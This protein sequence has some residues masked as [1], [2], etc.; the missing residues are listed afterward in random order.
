MKCGSTHIH[1]DLCILHVLLQ[2]RV[3]ILTMS[4]AKASRATSSSLVAAVL[5]QLA[6]C[7]VKRSRAA[8]EAAV[9]KHG[10][11]MEA[12]VDELLEQEDE[13]DADDVAVVA[14]RSA[15]P[16]PQLRGA[17]NLTDGLT[18]S[19]L[20]RL[21]EAEQLR[22]AM[23]LSVTPKPDIAAAA[24]PAAAVS[25]K[26]AIQADSAVS[27]PCSSAADDIADDDAPPS[28]AADLSRQASGVEAASLDW[29]EWAA[30]PPATHEDE[31][32]GDENMREASR[33]AAAPSAG[34]DGAYAA[35][36][37]DKHLLPAASPS[38]ESGWSQGSTFGDDEDM[39]GE[40]KGATAGTGRH[41]RETVF[42][43][44]AEGRRAFRRDL[45]GVTRVLHQDDVDNLTA[46]FYIDT[47]HLKAEL[48]YAMCLRP[49]TTIE[50]TLD[51]SHGYRG[52]DYPLPKITLEDAGGVAVALSHSLHTWFKVCWRL[53]EEESAGQTRYN[54]LDDMCNFVLSRLSNITAFCPRQTH[55]HTHAR[56]CQEQ[57]DRLSHRICSALM[58]LS[59]LFSMR[60][61]ASFRWL[62]EARGMLFQDV[63]VSIQRAGAG[64]LAGVRDS[65][66][67][68]GSRYEETLGGN[69]STWIVAAHL[70]RSCPAACCPCRPLAVHDIRGR[71]VGETTRRARAIPGSL[72]GYTSKAQEP[73]CAVATGSSS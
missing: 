62:I 8:V 20:A 52:G 22:I 28:A 41:V 15:P 25:S 24:A 43:R 7:E 56:K 36:A 55:T 23:E 9:A 4:K 26:P 11:N 51:A 3:C 71:H 72:H 48:S 29:G 61:Q 5:A 49:D 39:G 35:A 10:S 16:K 67:P 31:L 30:S 38:L 53:P 45:S 60:H 18:S 64:L 66:Q 12:C 19:A 32:D 37:T 46:T 40:S 17:F 21:S 58:P 14:V 68:G 47:S 59:M 44:E 70:T 50:L 63:L 33:N 69:A 6:T 54:L 13:E 2:I 27:K 57:R 1:A 65:H 42:S 73:V 34:A